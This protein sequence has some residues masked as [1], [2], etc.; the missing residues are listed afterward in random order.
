M[1]WHNYRPIVFDKTDWVYVDFLNLS[2]ANNHNEIIFN[3]SHI[4]KKIKSDEFIIVIESF[5]IDDNYK[6]IIYFQL[7]LTKCIFIECENITCI[8]NVNQNEIKDSISKTNKLIKNFEKIDSSLKK[9]ETQPDLFYYLFIVHSIGPI[10]SLI[11]TQFNSKLRADIKIKIMPIKSTLSENYSKPIEVILALMSKNLFFYHFLVPNNVYLLKTDKKLEIDY[12]KKVNEPSLLF[13]DDTTLINISKA[14]NDDRMRLF[15]QKSISLS[16]EN[17][18]FKSDLDGILIEKKIKKPYTTN[19]NQKIN[20]MD[21]YDILMPNNEFKLIIKV[22]GQ[23]DSFIVYYDARYSLHQLSILPGMRIRISNLIKKS[24]FI[25]KSNSF[26]TSS[27]DQKLNFLTNFSNDEEKNVKQQKKSKLIYDN[28]VSLDT[29]YEAF[30]KTRHKLDFE[31]SKTRLNLIFK[32]ENNKI[33]KI[34]GQI[35]KIYEIS[36]RLK[37]KF[38]NHLVDSCMCN[39]DSSLSSQKKNDTKIFFDSNR[40]KIELNITFLID[41]NTSL[42]K[43][44]YTDLDFNIKSIYS[45]IFYHISEYITEILFKYLNELYIPILPI[46]NFNDSDENYEEN[47]LKLIQNSKFNKTTFIDDNSNLEDS[48]FSSNK[49]ERV[50]SDIYKI[51]DDFMSN[52]IINRYFVFNICQ[53]GMMLSSYYNQKL[54]LNQQFV[55]MNDGDLNQLFRSI[56]TVNCIMFKPLDNIDITDL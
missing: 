9:I 16:K 44:I 2:K 4:L 49:E 48:I 12:S 30:Y 19:L 25:F 29:I 3:A 56:Q 11:N 15:S 5:K 27:Y 42:L 1:H 6:Y 13:I 41:D 53:K 34:I 7:D 17:S 33:L 31:D 51:I 24:D 36:I 45:N 47:L 38:C 23:I 32:I 50:M 54:K 28:L 18:N 35:L 26:L 21:Y 22:D 8:Y 20:L 46:Q 40:Y 55:K 52:T 37:C 39:L 43:V 10:F 14:E